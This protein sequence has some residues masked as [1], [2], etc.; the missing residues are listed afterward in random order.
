MISLFQIKD[1]SIFQRISDITDY[2]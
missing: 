2:N 1:I